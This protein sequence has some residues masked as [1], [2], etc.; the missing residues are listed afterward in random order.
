M[1]VHTFR[2]DRRGEYADWLQEIDDALG[3]AIPNRSLMHW[4]KEWPYGAMSC[5]GLWV[6]DVLTPFEALPS[7]TDRLEIDGAVTVVYDPAN[8]K[9]T[10]P[11]HDVTHV[12]DVVTPGPVN[13][14][15]SLAWD[16]TVARSCSWPSRLPSEETAREALNVTD[17]LPHLG[18]EGPD[19]GMDTVIQALTRVSRIGPAAVDV[20][21]AVDGRI[22]LDELSDVVAGLAAH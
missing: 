4:H 8:S 16:A 19:A 15:T 3:D 7:F 14:L 11:A 10:V 20:L 22:S 9:L 18:L 17:A 21:E 1:G 5:E 12:V 6:R 13:E 2:W